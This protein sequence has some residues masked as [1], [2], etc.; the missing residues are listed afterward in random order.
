MLQ[1][2]LLC[3]VRNEKRCCCACLLPLRERLAG[4]IETLRNESAGCL[5][6]VGAGQAARPTRLENAVR[7][8]GRGGSAAS[9]QPCRGG[10]RCGPSPPPRRLG[11]VRVGAYFRPLTTYCSVAVFTLLHC[12]RARSSWG[13]C[14]G[15][16]T[17]DVRHALKPWPA[18]TDV[19]RP[20]ATAV[21]RRCTAFRTVASGSASGTNCTERFPNWMFFACMYIQLICVRQQAACDHG[22]VV[23]CSS[24]PSPEEGGTAVGL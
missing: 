17:L 12:V 9:L 23:C 15:H 19:P 18:W 22:S 24:I 5:S 7:E 21:S 2:D 4:P 20:A 1:K 14:Y 16:V 10:G 11:Q 13:L 3:F 6:A 8:A